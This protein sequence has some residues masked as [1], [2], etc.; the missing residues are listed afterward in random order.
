MATLIPDS[1]EPVLQ[2]I[3]DSAPSK[4][5]QTLCFIYWR[6]VRINYF[7]EIWHRYGR[8]HNAPIEPFK[9]MLVS[10][11]QIN[12][13]PGQRVGDQLHP[14]VAGG[15]W[16]LHR[17]PFEEGA[18][19]QTFHDRFVD[20]QPWSETD[21]YNS[22]IDKYGSK[23]AVLENSDKLGEA[24]DLFDEVSTMEDAFAKYDLI[25]EQIKQEGYKLQ[26]QLRP[27]EDRL[28]NP[29]VFSNA[30]PECNEITLDVSRDGTLLCYSG[31][32]RLAMAKML[33]L[34]AVPVRIR[35]RHEQWQR[36][37]D[38]VWENKTQSEAHVDLRP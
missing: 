18:V 31:Q 36:K 24:F 25:F 14:L 16:D 9:L 32:H 33:D 26:R 20:N 37:R 13:Y 4:V 28:E 15:D 17:T 3:Y 23:Q 34:N 29:G 7:V 10:P 35:L 5:Q 21:R 1:I 6:V 12:H 38:T 30:V 11:S 2:S 22:Y 19:Y 27:M 8:H